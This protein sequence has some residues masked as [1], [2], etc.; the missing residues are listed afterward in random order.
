MKI[1]L[2]DDDA[3]ERAS[4]RRA[5]ARWSDLRNRSVAFA[6][7][8]AAEKLVEDVRREADP[9]DV[10]FLDVLMSGM[11]GIEAARALRRIDRRVP[12]VFCTVTADYALDGYEVRASGYLVKPIVEQ[13]LF[14]LLD[15]FCAETP[16]PR[17]AFRVGSAWRYFDYR[18][19]LYVESRDHAIVLHTTDGAVH[20]GY[21]K[22]DDVEG[23]LDDPRF[24]RCH[25]SYIVNM[26]HVADVQG[27][28]VLH[29]G[30][31]VPVRVKERRKLAEAYY[32]YF[33]DRRC[34]GS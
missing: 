27:D 6:E 23:A 34:A 31:R 13:R 22:L 33:V 25:R 21:G 17:L 20:K 4:L 24:L 12:I 8:G 2:C 15:D 10:L 30:S 9:F 11:S 29:D 5:I 26:D 16:S 7:Y 18:S 14:A 32:A 1:A 19:I 3:P 28:F